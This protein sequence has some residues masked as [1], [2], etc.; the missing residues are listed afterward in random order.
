[1]Q[2]IYSECFD[3]II[4]FLKKNHPILTFWLWF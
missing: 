3:A 2:R 1:M 4:F